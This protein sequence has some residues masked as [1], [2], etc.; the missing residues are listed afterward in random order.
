M[1]ETGRNIEIFAPFSEAFELMTKILFK[2]FDLGKWFV[3][4]FA[5]WL[6]NGFS[7]YSFRSNMPGN[8]NWKWQ[9]ASHSFPGTHNGI[10]VW[11]V[12][13]IAI[14]IVF[15][16]AVVALIIWLSSRGKFI[17]IDCLVKNRG[18][19]KEPWREYREEGNSFF[20]FRLLVSV[21]SLAI[22]GAIAIPFVL[23][24]LMHWGG[25]VALVGAAAL[26]I[27]LPIGVVFVILAVVLGLIFQLMA[28]VMYRRRCTAAAAF[29]DLWSLVTQNPGVFI[30]Y[31]LFLIVL[32]IAAVAVGCISACVTCC[33]TAIPYLG[34]VILLPVSVMLYAFPLCFLRQF[35]SDYDVW[36]GIAP[37]PSEPPVQEILPPS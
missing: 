19:I 10:P 16:L 1:D 24:G 34:T 27:L 5:A 2:P 29:Q 37:P 6:A 18:A 17:L 7:S 30:L 22:V 25:G 20:I 31:F 35:G 12:P 33:L 15:V 14:G 11:L 9:S 36:A 23:P 28:P 32:V 8:A 3:I 26:A 21:A 4:G 13:L